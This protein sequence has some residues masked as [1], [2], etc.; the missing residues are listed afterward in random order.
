MVNAPSSSALDI[1]PVM[2]IAICLHDRN[3]HLA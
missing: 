1:T 2:E 3:Q